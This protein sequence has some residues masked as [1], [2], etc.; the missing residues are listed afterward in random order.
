MRFPE[1]YRVTDNKFYLSSNAGDRFGA[2]MVPVRSKAGVDVLAVIASTDAD[3]EHVSVS[4]KSRT[5][6]W[7]EMCKVKDL[8]WEEHECV[9]Q[10]H[11]LKQDYVNLHKHCLHL[12]RPLKAAIPMPEIERV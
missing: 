2:F 10:Y 7:G 11:P 4:L 8:F 12:W 9:I 3:W 5:P 1:K 6:T